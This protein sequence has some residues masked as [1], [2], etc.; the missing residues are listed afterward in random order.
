MSDYGRVRDLWEGNENARALDYGGEI[1]CKCNWGENKAK[2]A[3]NE[4]N[5]KSNFIPELNTEKGNQPHFFA[6]ESLEHLGQKQ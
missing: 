1:L 2:L 4:V 3:V 6:Y 5:E